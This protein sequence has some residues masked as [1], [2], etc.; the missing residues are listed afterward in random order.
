MTSVK[1]YYLIILYHQKFKQDFQGTSLPVNKDRNKVAGRCWI[2]KMLSWWIRASYF[3]QAERKI[4]I[5]LSLSGRSCSCLYWLAA[6]LFCSRFQCLFFPVEEF[7][8]KC[9]EFLRFRQFS[10]FINWWLLCSVGLAF[11]FWNSI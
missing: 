4:D 2:C 1:W 8:W 3:Y 5:H 9:F 11:T 6:K 10:S 7:A